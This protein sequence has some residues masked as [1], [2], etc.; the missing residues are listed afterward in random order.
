M[1]ELNFADR[2]AGLSS[3]RFSTLRPAQAHVLERF[4]E[5]DHDATPDIAVELPT[6]EGKTLMALLIADWALDNGMSVAYLTGNKLLA[7]Q[8]QAE[9]CTLPGIDVHRFESGYYPGARVADYHQ[10]QAVGAM[11][12]WAYFNH[13]PKVEPELV[14]FDDAHLA[15]QPLAGL[16]TLRIPRAAGGG[17]GLYREICGIAIETLFEEMASRFTTYVSA[18]GKGSAKERGMAR[19]AVE[20]T[21]PQCDWLSQ[22]LSPSHGKLLR[23]QDV[24]D[25]FHATHA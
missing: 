10:A 20:S 15:E 14:I 4:A 8:V 1:A 7:T 23:R 3:K 24:V 12:Y 2:L 19:E 11:N 17:T 21:L 5:L 13:S 9:G 16:F 6:G 22:L 25:L 18:Y